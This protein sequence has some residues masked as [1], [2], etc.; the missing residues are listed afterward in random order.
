LLLTGKRRSRVV[1]IGRQTTLQPLRAGFG[2][3]L[4]TRHSDRQR[5]PLPLP[6]AARV[7]PSCHRGGACFALPQPAA[8]DDAPGACR[9]V[10]VWATIDPSRWCCAEGRSHRARRSRTRIPVCAAELHVI[11]TF[12]GHLLEDLLASSP[13][14][15]GLGEN[16]SGR[17][18]DVVR[19]CSG[20]LSSL[21]GLHA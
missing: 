11:E 8:G 10:N 19:P 18:M 21:G 6:T 4:T 17:A 2:A 9:E 5:T 15:T 20:P 3:D 7:Y 16:L 12:L 1:T 14:Q 13:S